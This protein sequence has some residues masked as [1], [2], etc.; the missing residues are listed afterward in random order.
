[1]PIVGQF[2]SLAGFGVFPGGALESIA[3]VTVGSGGASSIEFVDIPSG[4][5][6]LQVRMISQQGSGSGSGLIYGLL[7][8]NSDTTAGNYTSHHLYGTGAAAGADALIGTSY[9]YAYNAFSYLNTS[10]SSIFSAHI[11]DILDYANTS[12]NTTVRSFT[13]WDGNGSGDVAVTSNLWLSTAAVT[14]VTLFPNA[15]AS[16]T[17]KQFTTAALYGVKAP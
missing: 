12:K 2:G 1:M 9:S 13:G 11:V 17:F 14:T 6:H 7:R 16:R 3:T 10:T 4:F 15:V 5:Q 8:F